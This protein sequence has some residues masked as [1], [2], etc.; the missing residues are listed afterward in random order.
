M[1]FVRIRTEEPSPGP[2]AGRRAVLAAA[3]W[4]LAVALG[5]QAPDASPT[6]QP[7]PKPTP[8]PSLP[9]VNES[10]VVSAER[11]PVTEL[12]IPGEAEVVTGEQ[13]RARGVTNL[14]DGIQDVM[15]VDTGQGS[16]A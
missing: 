1:H 2:A 6:P 13:L 9:A 12:E 10:V 3:S 8:Q 16:D 11:G 15:G 7:T 4:L 5:A 14:A